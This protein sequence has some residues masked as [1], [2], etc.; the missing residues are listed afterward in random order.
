MTEQTSFTWKFHRIGGLDQLTL[1]TADELLHLDELDPK[2]WVALSCPVAGLQF[3]SR[4]L[5]LLDEDADGRIRMQEV[6]DA[7]RWTTARLRDPVT[8]AGE[9]DVFSLDYL[10]TDGEEGPRLA[11]AARRVLESLGKPDATALTQEDVS[12]AVRSVAMTEFNGD[13]IMPNRVE[14]PADIREFIQHVLNTCGSVTDAG[15]EPGV[16]LDL[17]RK[18]MDLVQTCHAWQ[19]EQPTC[20]ASLPFGAGTPEAFASFCAVQE[21]CDDYFIRCSL[22]AFEPGAEPLLNAPENLFSS[23]TGQQLNTAAM[24]GMST[25]PMARIAA[26]RALSLQTGL[27]P[28]WQDSIG[29]FQRTV[30][31]PLFGPLDSLSADTWHQVKALFAPYAA[32]MARKPDTE[33]ADLPP[34][35]LAALLQGDSFQ[36]F[37]ALVEQDRA[38]ADTV[39]LIGEV[40]RLVVYHRHLHRLLMNFV[41]FCDFYALSRPTTFQIGTLYI[42]GRSCE[43][44]I[45]VEDIDRHAQQAQL[46][47]LCLAYCRCVR[48]DHSEILNIVAA[49]TAGNSNLLIPGRHGVFVDRNGAAWDATLVRLV[50]NPIS[51]R[52]S[53]FAPY[54]RVARL[55][56]SQVEKFTAAKDSNITASMTKSVGKLVDTGTKDTAAAKPAAP[57]DI[58]R[59]M[60]IF[61]AIGLALG[62]LGTALASIAAALLSLSWWQLPLLIIGIFLCISGPSVFLAWLS[63]RQ[64][65]LGPVLDASGWAVNSKIPVNLMMGRFLT[66]S[67]SLPR[68]AHRS[69]NDPFQKSSAWKKRI[70][71]IVIVA[72]ILGCCLG[73]Y[74]G[75]KVYQDVQA[76]QAAVPDT[77]PDAKQSVPFPAAE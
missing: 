37:T 26:G 22:A 18:F 65:T 68:N 16:D 29:T 48:R 76:K 52:T 41:S 54:Q 67:A 8:L 47:R 31:T 40:E 46:S 69:L 61:A 55:V 75:W 32:I 36:H 11:A 58:G 71:A 66:A 45:R 25:L 24:E 42:D 12:G 74:W 1:R 19:E 44:C 5:E 43:L 33:V 39:A 38:G 9:Y 53:V 49:V 63:L 73:G 35:Q 4:A 34:A 57:F 70:I 3:D 20:A 10:R 13:G 51:I 62:A 14:F 28:A 17:A 50:D 27:N 23:F 21:K 2:L 30:L 64:R 56:A 6:L 72:A 59:S 60:G 7:V 15:G 77:A